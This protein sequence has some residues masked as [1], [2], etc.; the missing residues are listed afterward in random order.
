MWGH[1]SLDDSELTFS[2]FQMSALKWT[3]CPFICCHQEAISSRCLT[4]TLSLHSKL[5]VSKH[6]IHTDMNPGQDGAVTGFSISRCSSYP[7]DRTTTRLGTCCCQLNGQKGSDASPNETVSTTS[8]NQS[9]SCVEWI[10]H[11]TCTWLLILHCRQFL[12]YWW[13]LQPS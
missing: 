9:S 13:C 3:V 6:T 1:L 11:P 10:D 4:H 8:K 7:L 5:S 12:C 2:L